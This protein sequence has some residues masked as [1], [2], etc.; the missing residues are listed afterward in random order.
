MPA[1]L[2]KRLGAA[3]DGY[4]TGKPLWVVADTA[5]PHHVWA[6]P[7]S[8]QIAAKLA[9][10][11]PGAMAFGPYAAYEPA[12]SDSAVPKQGQVAPPM[13]MS[14]YF[15]PCIK[16]PDS[17]CIFEVDSGRGRGLD[18]L[19]LDSLRLKGTTITIELRH[20]NYTK[21]A[22][23]DADSLSAVFFSMSAVDNMLMPYYTH[24]YG[25]DEAARIRQR[26]FRKR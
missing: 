25:V 7:T 20:G 8:G 23:F 3:V 2:L 4:R 1:T 12:L 22:T 13:V 21:R 19:R 16:Q 24:L 5:F 17:Q 18:S 6:V 9:A 11:R 26:M 14:S 10:G 15:P